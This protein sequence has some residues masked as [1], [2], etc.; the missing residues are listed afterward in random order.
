MAIHNIVTSSAV[1]RSILFR[2]C[3]E[4]SKFTLSVIE[5]KQSQPNNH[6]AAKRHPDESG[7][8]YQLKGPKRGP[9]PRLPVRRGL[10]TTAEISPASPG[11]FTT[12][13]SCHRRSSCHPRE[14][15]DPRIKDW[16]PAFA[17]MIAFLYRLFSLL[18][19]LPIRTSCSE[20]TRVLRGA[21]HHGAIIYPC[22]LFLIFVFPLEYSG[23]FYVFL[24]CLY[25]SCPYLP[26]LFL[27]A[28]K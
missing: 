4:K 18:L 3:D 5:G 14:S 6:H 26:Y 21:G 10:L 28:S 11:T 9:V 25:P 7:I 20:F 8:N 19:Q 16:I 15:G 24:F 1:E 17:G 2:H 22:F 23:P 27:L 12:A 13:S